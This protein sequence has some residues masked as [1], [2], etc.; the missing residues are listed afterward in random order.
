MPESWP[1]LWRQKRQT[2]TQGGQPNG[3]FSWIAR[4]CWHWLP[5]F[6][7]QGRVRGN[8]RRMKDQRH[9]AVFD[10]FYRERR[11][12]VAIDATPIARKEKIDLC[13]PGLW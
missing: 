9:G 7:R 8:R 1:L 13:R 11:V 2:P 10:T 5:R 12:A 3:H 4:R 6:R